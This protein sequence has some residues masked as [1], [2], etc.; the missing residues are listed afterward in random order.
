[1]F[2]GAKGVISVTANIAPKYMARLCDAMQQKDYQTAKQIYDD[3]LYALHHAI[4]LETNPIPTKWALYKMGL[5]TSGIK[6]PLTMLAEQFHDTMLQA[7][8]MADI[9]V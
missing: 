7:M 1:M 8:A 5:I 2:A 3:K 6:L 9:E 4:A